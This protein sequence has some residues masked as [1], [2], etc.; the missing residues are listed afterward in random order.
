MHFNST[1][2]VLKLRTHKIITVMVLK[3]EQFNFT[4]R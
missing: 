3:M 2:K 1:V 4:E